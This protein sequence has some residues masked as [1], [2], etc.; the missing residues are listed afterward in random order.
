MF[1][2]SVSSSVTIFIYLSVSV[3]VI[4][5]HLNKQ[6][7]S[8]LTV[9]PMTKW[10]FDLDPEHMTKYSSAPTFWWDR[11]FIYGPFISFTTISWHRQVMDVAGPSDRWPTQLVWGIALRVESP[12]HWKFLSVCWPFWDGQKHIISVWPRKNSTISYQSTGLDSSIRSM[13]I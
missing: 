11:Q 5:W 6:I 9:T 3:V 1:K 2:V 12:A 13:I 4:S 8:F 10:E 7:P